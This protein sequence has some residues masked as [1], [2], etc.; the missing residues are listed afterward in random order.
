MIKYDFRAYDPELKEMS[1]DV[2][3]YAN[4]WTECVF[5]SGIEK[6]YK[7]N[8]IKIM[9]WSGQY[10]NNKNKIF[11]G[12]ILK[13]NFDDYFQ[14]VFEEGCFQ[15]FNVWERYTMLHEHLFF[16][17]VGN[18]FENKNDYEGWFQ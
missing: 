14:V 3:L 6:K 8:T 12:D 17:V 13:N 5:N 4:G 1:H 7:P 18:I 2:T 11:N 16:E 9:Q 15:A 10:D